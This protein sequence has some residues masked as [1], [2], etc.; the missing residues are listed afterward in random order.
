MNCIHRQ[1]MK[2]L[3]FADGVDLISAIEGLQSLVDVLAKC[4]KKVNR[5][6]TK[7]MIF[8]HGRIQ[9]MLTCNNDCTAEM[10]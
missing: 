1:I 10:K 8:K 3:Q 4:S 2:D 6:K 5:K 7:V 9:I